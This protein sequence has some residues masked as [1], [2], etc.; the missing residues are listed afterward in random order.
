M[1]SFS[2]HLS[3][4]H[5]NNLIYPQ[6]LS[7]IGPNNYETNMSESMDIIPSTSNDYEMQGDNSINLS[8]VDNLQH[9]FA[10]FYMKLQF[11]YLIPASTV[12]KIIHEF[13]RV[14]SF[15]HNLR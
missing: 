10:L 2:S 13:Q 3:R 11:K 14:Y 8:K 5:K 9:E 4:I 7:E 6:T 15:Q 1:S 12:T